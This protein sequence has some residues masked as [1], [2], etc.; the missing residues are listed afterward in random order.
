VSL[1]SKLVEAFRAPGDRGAADARA[2]DPAATISAEEAYLRHLLNR[3]TPKPEGA[4]GDVGDREFW[5]A[6]SR[7]VAAGRERT[8]IELL[9][10]FV[11]ARPDDAELAARLVELLCERKDDAAARPL[12]ERLTRSSAHTERAHFLLADLDERAGDEPAARR[13]LEEVLAVNLDHPRARARA[14]QMARPAGPATP[15]LEASTVLSAGGQSTGRYRLVRELGRGASGAVYLARDEELDRAL[16]LKI[17]H[18]QAR[19]AARAEA[20]ARAWLEARVAASIRHPGVVAVY[21]LDEERHLVAMELCEG[22]SLRQKVA[23]GPLAPQAALA[24]AAEL[25]GTL[26]AVHRRGIAH[27]DVKPGNLLLRS[28][29]EDADLVLVD[30]GLARLVDDS[31]QPSSSSGGAGGAGTLAYMAPEQRQ[32]APSPAAD[33]HAAGVILVELLCGTAALAGWLGD[34]AALLRGD[35]HWDGRFGTAVESLLGAARTARLRALAQAMMAA[36]AAA[37]PTAAEAARTLS[38]L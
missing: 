1:W 31:S 28:T 14:D 34:R 36:D 8:A 4:Q 2:P 19:G 38:T 16:A 24:R 18:P 37:R 6:I 20:R 13:H 5:A 10:R 21:D 33:V 11:V 17:L 23:P 27:G 32:G 30:F 29:A 22:G 12:L 9:G 15:A 26:E 3:P 25:C 7:L 35:A